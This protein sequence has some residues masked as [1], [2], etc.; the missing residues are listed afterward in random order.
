MRKWLLSI[1]VLAGIGFV[2]S[3]TIWC[4]SGHEYDFGFIILAI[5]FIAIAVI[6][7]RLYEKRNAERN[8]SRI[9]T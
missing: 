2:I 8:G 9:R 1:I 3:V 4:G 6:A 5:I 7:W